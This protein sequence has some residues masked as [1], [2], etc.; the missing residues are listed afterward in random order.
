MDLRLPTVSATEA[1]E[2]AVD[3]VVGPP[4]PG[5][6]GTVRAA[7]DGRVAYGGHAAR[8]RRH[9]L[10]P[11]LR[12]LQDTSGWISPGGLGYL[13]ERLTV[14]PA[15]AYGVASFYALLD[16]E[17]RGPLA[18]HV[19]DDIACAGSGETLIDELEAR[20]DLRVV[21][22][23]CLGACDRAPAC[24]AQRAGTGLTAAAPA[25]PTLEATAPHVE[26]H[27]DRAGLRLLRRVDHADP[28]SLDEYVSEGGGDALTLAASLGPDG[29]LD[30]L[31]RSGLR[32]RG[33]AAFPIGRKWRAVRAEPGPRHI[34]ANGDESEPGTFKDRLLMEGDPFAVVEAL[35]IGALAVGAE[36]AWI[37]VR[38]EYPDA[39]GR[40]EH[41]VRKAA[42]AGWLDHV[43]IT[44]RAGAGAYICG[45]ET[46]L[47]R[48]IEGHRGEP[49]QKPPFPNEA[50]LFGRPTAVNNIETLAA[51]LD[52]LV[53]GGD[54]YAAIGTAS[55]T[56]TKLFSVSGAVATPGVYEVPMGM[57]LG[58]LLDLAGG[59]SGTGQVGAV[60]LGGAAGSV[61]GADD[62]DLPLT[63]EDAAERGASLGSGAVVVFDDATDFGPVVR[64]IARFFAEESCGQCVPCRIGTVRQHEALVRLGS[65]RP[66]GSVADERARLSDLDVVMTDASICGLGRTAASAVRSAL[67]LGLTGVIP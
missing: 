62:L 34:V 47:F 53:L 33:G 28:G 23:P 5:P 46:A 43:D 1:E 31:D 65:G 67:R 18:V 14:P 66:L 32:G 52:V 37:Y 13:C 39:I 16:V 51:L 27:Q 58:D 6:A 44:V 63:F 10:L 8:D 40:L 20:P 21:R 42:A 56:G 29:V 22:S 36:Q 30:E 11:A 55:S 12:A 7:S 35:A 54:R 57:P 45:E 64:R 3:G 15:E 61:L 17:D 24:I 41:A 48:S 9:L 60:L 25:R 49:A 2:R 38:G 4:P 19:C 59:I 26:V 50:G